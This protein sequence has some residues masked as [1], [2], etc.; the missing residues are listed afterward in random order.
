M[1]TA[2]RPLGVPTVPVID[3]QDREQNQGGVHAVYFASRLL[4]EKNREKIQTP[5]FFSP[6]ASPIRFRKLDTRGQIARSAIGRESRTGRLGRAQVL[7][8]VYCDPQQPI[9]LRLLGGDAADDGGATFRLQPVAAADSSRRWQIE[10][11][12]AGAADVQEKLSPKSI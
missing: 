1:F 9:E 6:N 4:P 2:E 3:R 10:L 12:P 5:E 7:G 11:R 8:K